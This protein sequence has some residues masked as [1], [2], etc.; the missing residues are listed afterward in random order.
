MF[1]LKFV[2]LALAILMYALVIGFQEKKV[3]FTTIAAIIVIALGIVFPGK[4][5]TT[6]SERL[7][8]L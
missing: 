7:Y 8:A 1:S 3:W 6:G 4:I 5:F 2:I